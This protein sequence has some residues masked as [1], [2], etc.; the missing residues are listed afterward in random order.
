MLLSNLF[1][2][3][4]LSQYGI[5]SN[6]SHFRNL[7]GKIHDFDLTALLLIQDKECRACFSCLRKENSHAF[8]L[9]VFQ[10]QFNHA[11]VQCHA[12]GSQA[13]LPEGKLTALFPACTVKRLRIFRNMISLRS[14]YLLCLFYTTSDKEWARRLQRK[15]RSR[16]QRQQP[17]GQTD[18][19]K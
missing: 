10:Q 9:P 11:T 18:S 12:I 6:L 4:L 3:T 5:I 16:Q 13:V 15:P 2:Y 14:R 8:C 7:T 17:K 1:Q 19:P